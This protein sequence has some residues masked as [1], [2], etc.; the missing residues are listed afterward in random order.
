MNENSTTDLV[1]M[2]DFLYSEP[3]AAVPEPGAPVIFSTLVVMGGL[4]AAR[5]RI[6]RR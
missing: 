5:W 4:I 1:V 3:V 2:D 6:R